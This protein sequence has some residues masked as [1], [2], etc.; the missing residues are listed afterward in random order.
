[1]IDGLTTWTCFSIL[2]FLVGAYFIAKSLNSIPHIKQNSMFDTWFVLVCL[3]GLY[4]LAKYPLDLYMAGYKV[5]SII[6]LILYSLAFA[7]SFLSFIIV[8]KSKF[9]ELKI[10]LRLLF[11]TCSVAV[12]VIVLLFSTW[13]F[14]SQWSQYGFMTACGKW[15]FYLPGKFM[16]VLI[17]F[18]L[19]SFF[20]SIHLLGYEL[21]NNV[22]VLRSFA[23]DD[24]DKYKDALAKVKKACNRMKLNVLYI[25]NPNKLFN[26]I[27]DCKCYFLPT[28][29]W[30]N[31]VSILISKAKLTFCYLGV[32]E[33]I[34]WE[35]MNHNDK[36][37]SF[38]FYLS[39]KELG[40][41]LRTMLSNIEESEQKMLFESCLNS[42]IPITTV[43]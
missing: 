24:D 18:V 2:S 22:V 39:N 12:C 31:E 5:L 16:E 23:Y 21:D 27:Y 37:D 8:Y 6:I 13:T 34:L 36:W 28:T 43:H 9:Y 1:M 42:I 15:V 7:I 33:G 14:I 40:Y 38:I 35:L 19:P 26:R 17:F 32:S 29:N 4:F 25:G 3:I 11:Y 30:Q 20:E 10:T 41:K